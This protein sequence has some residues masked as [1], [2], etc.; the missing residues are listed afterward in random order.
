MRAKSEHLFRRGQRGTFHLRKRIPLHLRDAY[1]RGKAEVLVS[2]RTSDE[3][4]ARERLR[5]RLVALDPQ[6]E[7]MRVKLERRWTSPG[8]W[9]VQ[10]G[11]TSN[12]GTSPRSWVRMVLE[13]D[14]HLRQ[15]GTGRRRVR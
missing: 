11:R 4:L 8:A 5:A 12:C 15:Q 10:Q 7:R 13:T 3:Q 6:F 2:P 9:E 1:P 14:D